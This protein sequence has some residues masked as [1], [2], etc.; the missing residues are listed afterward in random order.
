MDDAFTTPAVTDA[1]PTPG[2]DRDGKAG[3]GDLGDRTIL[4]RELEEIGQRIVA[5]GRAV[6]ATILSVDLVDSALTLQAEVGFE[7]GHAANASVVALGRR[8]LALD[9]PVVDA[10]PAPPPAPRGAA[11]TA[12]PRWAC[13]CGSVRAPWAC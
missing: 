4:H 1:R 11:T 6:G 9:A 7:G 8:V 3:L 5:S 10:L 12:A 2:G 13:H